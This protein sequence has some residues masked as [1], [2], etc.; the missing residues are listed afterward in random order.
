MTIPRAGGVKIGLDDGAEISAQTLVV[1]ESC[2]IKNVHSE[3]GSQEFSEVKSTHVV[4]ALRIRGIDHRPLSYV[5]LPFDPVVARVTDVT[6]YCGGD[7]PQG[8]HILICEAPDARQ[9]GAPLPDPAE[10]LDYLKSL[11]VL[12][13]SVEIIDFTHN[14]LKL[15]RGDRSLVTHLRNLG[16]DAIDFVPS[17]DFA[18]SIHRN[19]RRWEKLLNQNPKT[20]PGLSPKAQTSPALTN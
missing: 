9:D 12:P 7:N 20:N 10:I 18:Y 1:S 13:D 8:T 6:N 2:A 4:L 16:S 17:G 19:R 15:R 11:K 5:E 14:H 3:Q